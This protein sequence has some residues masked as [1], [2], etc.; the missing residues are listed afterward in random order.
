[1]KKVLLLLANGYEASEA[2]VFI[3]VIG[4]NYVDGDRSTKLYTCGL[5]REV[6]T[7]FDQRSI[8]DYTVD[9]V[10]IDD[11]EA[12]AIPGGFEEYD[13]YRDGYSE[14][15]LDIIREFD[16]RGKTIASICVAA[17]PMGRSGVL[18]GRSAT[19]YNKNEGI[20]QKKLTEYGVNVIDQPIVI[21]RNIITSY[22]PSTAF[23]VAFTLLE[24][25]TS[26]ENTVKIKELMGFIK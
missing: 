22:N 14:K 23:D 21:D 26:K 13:F 15:F 20:R 19:T 24:M 3:D 16:R 12:L 9:E 5:T 2:S 8:V 25:L 17:L 11:Y 7:T 10:D 1:M 18:K 6:N 4:W